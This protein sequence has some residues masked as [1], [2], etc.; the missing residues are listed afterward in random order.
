MLV[1]QAAEKI[2]IVETR[3]GPLLAIRRAGSCFNVAGTSQGVSSAPSK[4]SLYRGMNKV[5]TNAEPLPVVHALRGVRVRVM[6]ECAR[7]CMPLSAVCS[8]RRL[9][10][11][12]FC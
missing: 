11:N 8:F 1:G 2:R 4:G 6:C 3:C 5:R 9:R 10:L 7:A 12:F